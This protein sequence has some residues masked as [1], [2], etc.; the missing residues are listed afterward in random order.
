MERF[1]ADPDVQRWVLQPLVDAGLKRDTIETLLFRLGFEAIVSGGRGL[2]AG[3]QRVAGGQSMAVKAAL[4]ELIDRM[5][6]ADS[7]AA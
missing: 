7:E 4:T 1:L 2:D 3:L 5:L 6:I